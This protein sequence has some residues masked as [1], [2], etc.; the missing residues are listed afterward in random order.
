MYVQG[1]V[2][3]L[4]Y[5]FSKA[6]FRTFSLMLFGHCV[7][8]H[9]GIVISNLGSLVAKP[10]SKATLQVQS[11]NYLRHLQYLYRVSVHVIGWQAV[12]LG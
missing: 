9:G 7:R 3:I 5:L 8:I 12:A 10:L 2:E 4:F 1:I 6:Q 11:L